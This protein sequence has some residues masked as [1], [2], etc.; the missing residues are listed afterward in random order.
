M[1]TNNI[2]NNSDPIGKDPEIIKSMFKQVASGYD[3]ANTV[4]S[5]GIHH[6]WRRKAIQWANPKLGQ[7]VLDCA[8]GTGD[9][10]I[11]FKKMVG[12]SGHVIASDF[13]TEM[14]STGPA[15]A[16]KLG[17]EIHFQEADAMA[18]P[19]A[20]SSFDFV[21]IAFGIRNVSSPKVAIA[22][23]FRVLKPNGKLVVLEFGQIKTPVLSSIYNFYSLKILPLIGGAITGAP[24]AYEYLQKSSAEFP[25]GEN[26][27]ELVKNSASFKSVSIYSMSFGLCYCY[28]AQ[29]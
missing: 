23:M 10:A 18:L 24:K 16:Q 6:T 14:M 13:C 15:K 5:L 28:I 21:S 9:L 7:S 12:P 1:N 20:D 17:L 3:Q 4:L 2:K 19:F 25:S 29:K 11:E 26:F 22:E 8:T 27:A